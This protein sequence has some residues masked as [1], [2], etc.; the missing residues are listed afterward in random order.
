MN[1]I[2]AN[3]RCGR[4]IGPVL[5]PARPQM[6]N[7]VLSAFPRAMILPDPLNPNLKVDLLPAI[8][9][10]PLWLSTFHV[11]GSLARLGLLIGRVQCRF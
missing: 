7:L 5:T 8:A 1:R 2:T 11:T 10:P 9:A 3:R 6:R 4:T